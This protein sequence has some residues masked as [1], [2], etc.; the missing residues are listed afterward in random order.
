[1]KTE[2]KPNAS[3]LIKQ[4]ETAKV[5]A[6]I[7]ASIYDR[8]VTQTTSEILQEY[9]YKPINQN[10]IDAINSKIEANV[11]SMIEE[12]LSMGNELNKKDFQWTVRQ[13]PSPCTLVADRFPTNLEKLRDGIA[14]IRIMVT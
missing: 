6:E 1:M 10:L 7:Q 3:E 2:R 11:E 14:D 13:C 4:K 9:K 5:Q 12:Q 8:I